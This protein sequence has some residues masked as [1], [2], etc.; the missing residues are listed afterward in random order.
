MGEAFV[1]ECLQNLDEDISL[2]D[3]NEG[4]PPLVSLLI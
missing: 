4:Q 1:P 2:L 3:H